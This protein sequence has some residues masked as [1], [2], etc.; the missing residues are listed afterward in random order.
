L[1]VLGGH[2][3]THSTIALTPAGLRWLS[4]DSLASHR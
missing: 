2:R 3:G 4:S 1:R